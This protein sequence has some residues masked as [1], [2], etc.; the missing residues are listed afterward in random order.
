MHAFEP[1]WGGARAQSGRHAKI[2]TDARTR[3]GAATRTIC[4][5]LPRSR[6]QACAGMLAGS[7]LPVKESP[8]I[9]WSTMAEW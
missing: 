2:D 7:C 9:C 8:C 6:F 4:G 3:C 5:V 1:G